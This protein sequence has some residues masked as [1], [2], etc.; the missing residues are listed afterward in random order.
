MPS[1]S[2]STQKAAVAEF[3]SVTQADKSTA[4]KL[5][6]QHNYNVQAAINA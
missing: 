5:V 1:V 2:S 3:I 4:S 6:K